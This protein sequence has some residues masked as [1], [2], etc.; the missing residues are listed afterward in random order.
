[1]DETRFQ[2]A[3]NRLN[4]EQ[5]EAVDT[6]EG[7]VMIIAGPGTGKTQ[8]LTLRIAN[9]LKTTDIGPENILALT[10]TESGAR[11]MRERLA[12]YIGAPAYRVGIHTFHEFAGQLIRTYPD[13]YERAVGGRPITDL[14]KITLIESILISHHKN[15]RPVVK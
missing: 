15:I 9:I 3:Y 4:P 10:F 8:I 6:V 7:P 13:A 14:E 12:T 2:E 1:M 11:A 5:K